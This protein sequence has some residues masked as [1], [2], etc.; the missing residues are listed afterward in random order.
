MS[1]GRK[2]RTASG[3]M[4]DPGDG[5][6]AVLL[7]SRRWTVSTSRPQPV[8]GAFPVPSASSPMLAERALRASFPLGATV[9]LRTG[10]PAVDDLAQADGW[11]SGRT[12]R[13]AVI[14]GLLLG[15][16]EL[17]SGSVAAVRLFGARITGCLD[18]ADG[19][20]V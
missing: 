6:P 20:L 14:T 8:K 3:L 12:V 1:R 9:D 4:P 7:I 16:G 2:M 17:R 10:D 11:G 5:A 15:A 19:Q 18:L 13:A